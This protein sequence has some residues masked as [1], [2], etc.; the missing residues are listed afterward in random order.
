MAFEIDA[1]GL[2]CPQPVILVKKALKTWDSVLVIVDN[3][4]ARR[5]VTA[6]A[7]K[8][9]ACWES[10]KE[11]DDIRIRIDKSGKEAADKTAEKSS[12]AME[13]GGNGYAVVVG[14]ESM[15]RG[16]SVLG[17]VLMRGFF[18]ALNE[19]DELPAQIIFFN[20]GVKHVVEGSEVLEDLR[21]LSEKGVS[22]LACG[23]CLNHFN[24]KEKLAVGAVSNMYAI[25]ETM[26]GADKLIQL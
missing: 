16:D 10:E 25:M 17:G 13:S 19:T 1:R 21:M 12:G 24:L 2:A 14:D 4:I 11:G 5:N 3:D 23:T 9:G 6:L 7:Q 26:T 22:I 18:H 20:S 15:G 8:L